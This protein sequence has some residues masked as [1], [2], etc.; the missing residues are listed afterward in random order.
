MIVTTPL[1]KDLVVGGQ[2]AHFVSC[3]GVYLRYRVADI[4]F[5]IPLEETRG[6]YFGRDVRAVELMR[7]LRKHLENL[8]QARSASGA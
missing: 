5:P 7:W 4:E 3:D 2:M 8:S 1:L 6:G